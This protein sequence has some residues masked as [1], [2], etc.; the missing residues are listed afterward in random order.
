V[1][2]EASSL[3]ARA[4]F[5]EGTSGGKSPRGAVQV[6]GRAWGKVPDAEAISKMSSRRG[7][8]GRSRGKIIFFHTGFTQSGL[9][10][11]QVSVLKKREGENFLAVP[12]AL[13]RG[14]GGL[15]CRLRH[16]NLKNGDHRDVRNLREETAPMGGADLCLIIKKRKKK[17]TMGKLSLR[18]DL[19][20]KRK[21][22]K[23]KTLFLLKIRGVKRGKRQFPERD[24]RGKRRSKRGYLM[25]ARGQK[26]GNITC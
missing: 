14:A 4:A 8:R 21:K 3:A 11:G 24:R 10:V 19:K 6:L 13:I 16:L 25:R 15:G 12:A 23:R 22:E 18:S 5:T 9:A 1:E 7:E 26:R 20:E 17:R 2:K